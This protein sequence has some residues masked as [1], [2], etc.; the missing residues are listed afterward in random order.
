[1]N[2]R[3]LLNMA[4]DASKNAYAPHSGYSVGAAIECADGTVYT[5]CNIE[6]SSFGATLCAERVALA[7]A[8]SE[9]KRS[10]TRIAIFGNGDDYC[11]PCGI[12]RQSLA[13]FSDDIEILCAKG[14]G[15]YVS[16]KIDRLLP[17]AFK[18]QKT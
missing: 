15:R 3:E 16:Y 13:E 2:D 4:Y 12:C 9:G 18:F 17:Y 10:F 5:G 6:N 1:M 8:L 7:K 11:M 14:D